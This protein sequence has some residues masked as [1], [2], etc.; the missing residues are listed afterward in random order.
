MILLISI[1]CSSSL[2]VRR[3]AW[4]VQL[5][6][7]YSAMCSPYSMISP[8]CSP[9]KASRIDTYPARSDLTSVPDSTMPASQVFRIA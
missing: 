7:P 2:R 8:S 4:L 1:R 5:P 3:G 6:K 9:A